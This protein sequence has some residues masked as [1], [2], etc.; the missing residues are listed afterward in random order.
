MPMNHFTSFVTTLILLLS[1]SLSAQSF[2]EEELEHI[3]FDSLRQLEDA[4]EWESAEYRTLSAIHLQKAKNLKDSLEIFVGY[5]ISAWNWEGEQGYAYVDSLIAFAEAT[6]ELSRISKA[7]YVKGTLYYEDVVPNKALDEFI[8]SYKYAVLDNNPEYEVLSLDLISSIKSEHGEEAEAI[9]LKREVLE[10]LEENETK[11]GAFRNYD[12]R[13]ID[14]LDG[15][16]RVYTHNDNVDSARY[17]VKKGIELS[18]E[19]E[20]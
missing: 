9:K 17:F 12:Q 5:M 1:C 7:H 15:L 14:I 13:M 16:A 6:G 19:S 20:E 18:K 8:I 4:V 3:S 11:K 10:I 2:S